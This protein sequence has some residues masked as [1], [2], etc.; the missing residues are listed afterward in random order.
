M[1]LDWIR[2][3][4]QMAAQRLGQITRTG[5]VFDAFSVH[6]AYSFPM[7]VRPGGG[8]DHVHIS[9]EM[10][11][12]LVQHLLDFIARLSASTSVK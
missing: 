7:R 8:Y 4:N 10:E 12:V 1:D 5:V 3:F 6:Q 11:S 9:S 2:E